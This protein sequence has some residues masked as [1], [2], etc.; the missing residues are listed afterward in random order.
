MMH[1]LNKA[2]M[3]DVD[4][5]GHAHLEDM[6]GGEEITN[7]PAA[8]FKGIHSVYNNAH[9]QGGVNN[10]AEQVIDMSWMTEHET[11]FRRN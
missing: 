11:E 3:S 2:S 7:V 10:E 4:L 5:H 1:L 9:R 8:H 6:Q